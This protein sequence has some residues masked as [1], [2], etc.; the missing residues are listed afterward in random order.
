MTLQ[1]I[2]GSLN[3]ALQDVAVQ[4]VAPR[5]ADPAPQSPPPSNAKSTVPVATPV[6]VDSGPLIPTASLFDA[7]GVVLNLSDS[8]RDLMGTLARVSVSERPAF[9]EMVADLLQHG[10]V[11]TETLEVNGEPY[12]AFATTRLG[13]AQLRHAKPYHAELPPQPRLDIR[14]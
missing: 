4:A 7:V 1:G 10:V 9:I 3:S 12:T 5:A 11:G 14:I 8:G 6:S 2:Q 13:D